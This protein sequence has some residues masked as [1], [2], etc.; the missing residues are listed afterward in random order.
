MSEMN[1]EPSIGIYPTGNGIALEINAG[2]SQKQVIVIDPD[3]AG[4]IAVN[5]ITNIVLFQMNM[6]MRAAQERA[7]VE[8]LKSMI[9]NPGDV[10]NVLKK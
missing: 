6:A 10:T 4:Q 9:T 1:Q 8:R 3:S 7:E 5:L 2:E